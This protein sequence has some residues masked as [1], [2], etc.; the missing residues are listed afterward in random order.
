MTMQIDVAAK[1]YPGI[2]PPTKPETSMLTERLP[3]RIR[4][5]TN[6]E[7]M[8]KVVQVRYAAYARHVPEFAERLKE[9][10]ANDFIPG[11]YILLAESK[12][13]GTA[14]GTMRIQTNRYERLPMERSVLLPE[15]LQGL[16]LLEATRL[17]VSEGGIGRVV[18]A[19]LLKACFTYSKRA[20]VDWMVITARKPLDRQYDSLMFEDVFS[21][22]EFIPMAHVGNIPHRVMAIDVHTAES[23]WEKAH[24]PLYKF[25]CRTSH[26]DID[27]VQD[28]ILN[29]PP[30]LFFERFSPVR[31][32]NCAA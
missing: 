14:L 26:P 7:Q 6:E 15:W 2:V 11:T 27:V 13:D 3:F 31:T 25:M 28:D 30:A 8:Q 19:A 23:R 16:T 24:H 4:L 18:K 10:E 32:M 17:G 12:L 1:S 9:P 22:G 20:M 29:V 5:A 21:A